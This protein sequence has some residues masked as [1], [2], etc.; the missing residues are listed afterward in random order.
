MANLSDMTQARW[1]SLSITERDALRDNSDL[2]PQLIDLEGWRVEVVDRE[3]SGGQT[4]RFIVGKSTGW[5]PCHLEISRR[6]AH[7]GYPA[8]KEYQSVRKLYRAR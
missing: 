3:I 6:S 1:Q 4:R 7:G 8:F 2:S 5:R